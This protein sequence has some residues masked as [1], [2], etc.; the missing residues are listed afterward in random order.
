FTPDLLVHDWATVQ[1]AL[2][3]HVRLSPEQLAPGPVSGLLLWEVH[4]DVV[5]LSG[6]VALHWYATRLQPSETAREAGVLTLRREL[7]AS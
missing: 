7:R 4:A 1:T 5:C 3:H 2:A 6:L